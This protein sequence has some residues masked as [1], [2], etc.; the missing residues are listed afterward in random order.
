MREVEDA[1]SMRGWQW[2]LLAEACVTRRCRRT[3]TRRATSE[4]QLQ[5]TLSGSYPAA[6][7]PLPRATVRVIPYNPNAWAVGARY[8]IA[9][10]ACLST[11]NYI[12]EVGSA[13]WRCRIGF[14]VRATGPPTY[15]CN[16]GTDYGGPPT[17]LNIKARTARARHRSEASERTPDC[18]LSRKTMANMC[19]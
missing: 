18:G 4:S 6:G 3:G 10:S 14:G 11:C 8:E 12:P 1:T 5:W 16:S 19:F 9:P 7:S 17:A 2:H 15:T 13:M